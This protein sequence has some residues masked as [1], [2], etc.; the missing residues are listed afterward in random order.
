LILAQQ[1]GKLA[2]STQHASSNKTEGKLNPLFRTSKKLS[3]SQSLYRVFIQT[4][5]MQGG[6]VD[7]V[8]SHLIASF[9]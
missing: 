7:F 5:A 4:E 3:A 1:A 2:K 6:I 9:S 8:H